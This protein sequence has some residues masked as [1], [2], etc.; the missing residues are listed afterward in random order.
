MTKQRSDD[1]ERLIQYLLGELREEEQGQIEE[2]YFA[3]SDFH[4]QLRAAERDLIDQYVHGELSDRLREQ[5]ERSYL[6]SPRRRQRVEF[7]TALMQSLAQAPAVANGNIT[8]QHHLRWRP[9]FLR[10]FGSGQRAALW[11][12]A[13]VVVLVGGWL[14]IASWQRHR[15]PNQ[16][17]QVAQQGSPP[18][19]GSPD[20]EGQQPQPAPPRPE[21]GQPRRPAASPPVRVATFV[22]TPSLARDLNETRKLI[23]GGHD[24]VRLQLHLEESDYKSYRAIL[25]TAEGDEIWNQDQ[26][27]PRPT[28]S[29][30]AIVIKLRASRFSNR[31]YTIRLGGVTAEGEV[32]EVSS[33]YFRVEKR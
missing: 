32:E 27:T 22:L 16:E 3:D 31:D 21:L 28:R 11:A 7:S 4:Q 6:S 20:R 25:R 24:W 18:T 13:A 2:R 29:G 9:S 1:E 33:Y 26:L 12:A 19:R 15:S 30:Q 5:F 10:Y 8:G 23:I 14:L 17:G